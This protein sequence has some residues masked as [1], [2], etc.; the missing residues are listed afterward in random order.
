MGLI[1]FTSL[2]I[3]TF[4]MSDITQAFIALIILGVFILIWKSV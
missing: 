1:D 2:D 4:L 3:Y